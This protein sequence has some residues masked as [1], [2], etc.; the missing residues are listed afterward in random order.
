M[1]K[2]VLKQVKTVAGLACFAAVGAAPYAV[3]AIAPEYVPAVTVCQG[4]L[5]IIGSGLVGT[6]AWQSW[7]KT[8]KKEFHH[9]G[10][11]IP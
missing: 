2:Q 6:A 9:I 7:N 1:I 4:V 8:A 3:P 11:Y 10:G 5:A